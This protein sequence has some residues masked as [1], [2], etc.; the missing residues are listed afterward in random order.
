MNPLGDAQPLLRDN[1][2][3]TQES[4]K[5]RS[6]ASGVTGL[7]GS[8]AVL[9]VLTS[10]LYFLHFRT[11]YTPNSP[12]YITPAANM[13]AGHGFTDADGK[14]ETVRT[15]GYP[16]FI[17]PFLWIKLDLK[18]V[19]IF[20]HLIRVLIVVATSAF[21]L[22]VTRSRRQALIAGVFLCIDLPMLEAA[23]AIMT[24]ILFTAI[25]LSTM[26]LLW[27]RSQAA[28]NNWIPP[29]LLAGISVQIRPVGLFLFVPATI[30][31][32]LMRHTSKAKAILGFLVAFSLFPAAWAARNY[33]QTG[34]FT[35][36]S[37][38]GTNMLLW[39]AA[40]TL[41]IRDPGDFHVNLVKRQTELQ[42]QACEDLQR[43]NGKDC[44]AMSAA[45]RSE[46]YAR[47]GTK[48]VAENVGSYAR[49][50]ARS[51]AVMMLDG[52]PTSLAG[53][54]GIRQ[55]TGIR[56]L[57]VYTVPVFCLML[58]GLQ[59]FWKE[60]RPFFYLC[61]LV[62]SYFVIISAGAEAYSRLRVPIDPICALL[63]AAGMD[64]AFVF[65]GHFKKSKPLE[66]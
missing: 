51:A 22:H 34:Y 25:L 6:L 12:G 50:A 1:R 31:L 53:I 28:W 41:A 9:A 8:I 24:E 20:Q 16:L 45:Q 47:L 18:Y 65:L 61:F 23:N 44:S 42:R 27:T 26:W 49:M 66:P 21:A 64:T 13:L 54:T 36:S 10:S 40:G 56:I 48:I 59:R 39:R 60:N 2:T 32:L 30:Y 52:G 46:Y 29:G 14:P 19:V 15:P 63:T 11:V 3:T 43:L 33:Y 62:I 35:V 17:L 5:D 38:T 7:L 57:L 55:T 4:L 37:I 58:V